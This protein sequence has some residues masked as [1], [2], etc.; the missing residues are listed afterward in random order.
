[1]SGIM[2]QTGHPIC[3]TSVSAITTKVEGKVDRHSRDNDGR[4]DPKRNHVE[5]EPCG[6]PGSRAI[7][8]IRPLADEQGT[9]LDNTVEPTESREGNQCTLTAYKQE[10]SS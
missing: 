9:V 1:M 8:T 5:C 6:Q 4:D 3:A 7:V 10:A 2:G